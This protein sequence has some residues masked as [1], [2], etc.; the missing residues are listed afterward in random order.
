MPLIFQMIPK[1]CQLWACRFASGSLIEMLAAG[2]GGWKEMHLLCVD[3]S[4]IAHLDLV[5]KH[6]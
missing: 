5:E 1:V 2:C 6:I 4:I 3:S